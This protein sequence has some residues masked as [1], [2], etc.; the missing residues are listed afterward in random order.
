MA[1]VGSCLDACKVIDIT[2]QDISNTLYDGVRFSNNTFGVAKAVNDHCRTKLTSSMSGAPNAVNDPNCTNI[3]YRVLYDIPDCAPAATPQNNASSIPVANE[4]LIPDTPLQFDFIQ[5]FSANVDLQLGEV[6]SQQHVINDLRI[7][8]LL[9]DGSL[10]IKSFSLRTAN[11]GTLK[12]KLVLESQEHGTRFGMKVF[13][14]NL[15]LGMPAETAEDFDKLPPYDLRLV[16]VTSGS[17]PREMAGALNGYLKLTSGEGQIKASAMKIL[18]QDFLFELLNTVNPFRK[19][20]PY[21]KI[22]CTVVL[23]TVEDGQ[24]IGKPVLVRQS[25]RL[26]IFVDTKI[27]LKTESLDADIKTVPVKGLGLSLGNLVNPYIKVVGTFANPRIVLN[28]ES[29]VLEGGAAVAVAAVRDVAAVVGPGDLEIVHVFRCDLIG[30]RVAHAAPVPAV[31]RPAG[32]R[33]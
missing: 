25:D 11:G 10:R 6:H 20:V 8:G 28:S 15:K 2:L 14:E 23:A 5:G 33:T 7:T 3:T 12:G 24:L 19:T 21:S 16:F 26:N 4:R 9:A 32:L 27:D 1:G 31:M 17:T 13:G 18:T 22:K 29:V 30:G